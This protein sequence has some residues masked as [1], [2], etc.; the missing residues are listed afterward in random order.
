MPPRRP[1]RAFIIQYLDAGRVYRQVTSLQ[2]AAVEVNAPGRHCVDCH[3][4]GL[5]G[6]AL[7]VTFTV[8]AGV[9]QRFSRWNI[10]V[11][12]QAGLQLVDVQFPFIVA[13]IEL[14]GDRAVLMPFSSGELIAN[15]GPDVLQ[16][17]FPFTWQFD[18]ANGNSTH[19][20]GSHFAQFMA[21]YNDR[22]GL[23]LACDDTAAM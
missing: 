17:D 7:E 6:M 5:A 9:E 14:G 12:N 11:D 3:Y 23:Y 20:P 15:P 2:A 13:N 22:A 16:P 10:T 18:P 21:Y 4:S 8:Q 1:I 19:Y